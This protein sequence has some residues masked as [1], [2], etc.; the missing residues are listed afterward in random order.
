MEQDQFLEVVAPQEAARRWRAVLRLGPLAAEEVPLAQAHG[1]VLAADVGAPGDVPGFH[2]SD[3]DGFAVR[4]GDLAG[5]SE[6]RPATLRWSGARLG[7]GARPGPEH[8]VGAGEAVAVETGG[9]VPRGADAVVM[10]EYTEADA[11]AGAVRVARPAVPGQNVTFAGADVTRGET[12]LWAGERLSARETG[13]LAALGLAAVACV[14]RPRVAVLSTGNELV[15]PG[16]PLG[17]GQIHDTNARLVADAVREHGGVP[18]ELG[19]CPDDEAELERR[20]RAAVSA[21]DMVVLSG[22]TSKGRGDHSHQVIGRLGAP[23][24]VVH[25]V[26]LKPGKPLCL[27]AVGDVPVVVLP[28]FPVSAIVTF[29]DFVAPVLR[30]LGG[31]PEASAAGTQ[32]V[33]ARAATRWHGA[34]GRREYRLVHLVPGRDGALSAYGVGKGSGSITGFARADGFV[35]IDTLVEQVFEGDPVEVHL[36]A[37]ADTAGGAAALDPARTLTAI[38]SH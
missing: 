21:H 7:A 14:R 11:A 38:G 3:V 16:A 29:L 13:V 33:A 31:L 23:G 2:R 15:A 20:L 35:V 5:A 34:K 9:V 25:G 36:L 18:V 24:V 32:V 4:A 10:V 22:G 28:G 6:D 27:G 26:A 12:V 8:A 19:I 17:E 30:L 37:G 1:R